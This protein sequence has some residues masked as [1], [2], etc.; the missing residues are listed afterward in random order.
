MESY[1]TIDY[2]NCWVNPKIAP[3][4]LTIESGI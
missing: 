4:Y 1:Y 3:A 2:M